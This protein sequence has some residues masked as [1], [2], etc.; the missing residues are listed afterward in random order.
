VEHACN[1]STQEVEV[2]WWI[3]N[4]PGLQG[5][6]LPQKTKE[7]NLNKISIGLGNPTSRYIRKQGMQEIGEHALMFIPNK[8]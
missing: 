4:Q 1:L 6:V 7:E 5:E 8:K 2:G 3:W